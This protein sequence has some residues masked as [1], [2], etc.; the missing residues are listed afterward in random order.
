[1]IRT[2]ILASLLAVLFLFAGPLGTRVGI[3]PFIVGFVLLG[4]SL[5]L[6]LTGASLSLFAAIRSGAWTAALPG[7]L[8]GL[9]VVAVPSA[10]VV[11]ARGKP[12]I[13]DI[14]TDPDSPPPFVAL[15]AER[16]GAPNPPEY[17]GARVAEQ[18]RRAYPDIQPLTLPLPPEAAFDRVRTIVAAAGW[19][20]AAAERG[21]GRIEAVD[22]TFWFGFNDDV[23]IRIRPEG[24]GSRVDVR[25][26]SRVGVGDLG[27]NAA[28]IREF[29]R[30]LRAG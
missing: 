29:T 21:E 5:L 6:G 27:A 14:T 12:P 10:V 15:L 20:V 1:V 25:S 3:W 23:V 2:G 22:T 8:I 7:I 17:G 9:A 18:Q 24:A 28:R 11:S 19:R 13:N 26:K 16:A 30:R 4:A